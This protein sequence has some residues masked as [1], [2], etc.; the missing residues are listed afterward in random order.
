MEIHVN[1]FQAGWDF[2]IRTKNK[3]VI[4][5]STQSYASRRNA[6]AAAKLIAGS[7]LKVIVEE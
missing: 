6:L 1:Q 3:K 7:K 5:R 2:E 4:A